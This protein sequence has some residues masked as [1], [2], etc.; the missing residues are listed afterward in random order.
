M[1]TDVLAPS[2]FVLYGAHPLDACGVPTAIL[3]YT[4]GVGGLP[5][6]VTL[7]CSL[8]TLVQRT[9]VV[10]CPRFPPSSSPTF[11]PR[12]HLFFCITFH[13]SDPTPP[14]PSALSA[15]RPRRV[16]GR[17]QAGGVV[18]MAPFYLLVRGKATQPVD[19]GA[20]FFRALPAGA[21][22]PG[23]LETA[24]RALDAQRTATASLAA[25]L[26]GAP[27]ATLADGGT[28]VLSDYVSSLN[29]FLPHAATVEARLPWT[30][31]F[32][33]TRSVALPLLSF[34]RAA[35]LADL[36]VATAAAG[37]AEARA[38][39]AEGHKAALK[40]FKV[41][42]GLLGHLAAAPPPIAAADVTVDLSSD[43]LA[44]LRSAMLANAQM[45]YYRVAVRAK[46]SEGL[47]SKLAAGVVKLLD[48]TAAHCGAGGL[49]ADLGAREVLATPVAAAARLFSAEAHAHAAAVASAGHD[50][51][52][53]LGHL[54]E[55]T[56]ALADARHIVRNKMPPGAAI[57][58]SILQRVGALEGALSVRQERADRENRSIYL[59]TAST[60]LPNIEARIAV[61]PADV[62][63][64]ATG[65]AGADPAS[66][67]LFSSTRPGA[68]TAARAAM[69][70]TAYARQPDGT[71]AA[72]AADAA[73][74]REAAVAEVTAVAEAMV[75]TDTRTL[76]ESYTA[77]QESLLAADTAVA[78]VSSSPVMRKKDGS[79][80]GGVGGSS[81]AGPPLS[82]EVLNN[83]RWAVGMGGLRGLEDLS[84]EVAAM[85]Q[86]VQYQVS[87][88]ER[89]LAAEA[90]ADERL[91]ADAHGN[92][93]R[94]PSA[95]LTR[96]YVATLDRVKG[97]LAT[98]AR[99]D[100]FVV[101]R[102]AS[103]RADLGRLD[104][105]G[106][107]SGVTVGSGTSGGGGVHQHHHRGG[108]LGLGGLGGGGRSDD[109]EDPTAAVTRCLDPLH[110]QMTQAR[111]SL[112]A[113][114]DAVAA[115]ELRGALGGISPDVSDVP[116]EPTSRHEWAQ[117]RAAAALVRPHAHA[118]R[119]AAEAR[120]AAGELDK[121][122]TAL[123]RA[124]DAASAAGNDGDGSSSGGGGGDSPDLRARVA[125]AAD[126]AGAARE[127]HGFLS[128]GVTFYT[129][130]GEVLGKLLSDVDGWVAARGWTR[131]RRWRHGWVSWALGAG[132]GGLGSPGTC[133]R[134]TLGGGR[135]RD[136]GRGGLTRGP[137]VARGGWG[138][139]RTPAR[140]GQGQAASSGRSG[141]T[142]A[143]TG[144]TSR[145]VVC[146]WVGGWV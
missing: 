47:A 57:G 110:P 119:L 98:A 75:D 32:A 9:D 21:F 28:K 23:P 92:L 46:V 17:A 123:R 126:A 84:R 130:E 133:R 107:L 65:T 85:S 90:A 63:A 138:E 33:P 56:A 109:K 101:E 80:S 27:G 71:A 64:L 2:L 94:P 24:C 69:A 81:N 95:E 60:S 121:G 31:A 66:V 117:S 105:L 129:K 6:G 103:R 15:T 53:Q 145:S 131:T 10:P 116:T 88:V 13:H 49:E 68:A 118:V 127:L 100:A 58:D 139:A 144:V 16:A 72:A 112:S 3:F 87:T 73:R 29:L 76:R 37:A 67:A 39:A 52:S 141:A 20:A 74:E 18:A 96:E 83:V 40:A 38:S 12:P 43:G 26:A 114:E 59:Q 4:A 89:A 22:H 122:V 70:A 44:A 125:A 115:A 146:G 124:A 36:A 86:K 25:V 120:R 45:A 50:M 41:A 132:V 78:E 134:P 113:G 14:F 51:A 61:E 128:Q 136:A 102:L 7:V 77:L 99:S 140:R 104:G 34:E 19:I 108:F 79:S 62:D 135:G 82:A 93:Q 111:A 137:R 1:S 54:R 42:A 35:V 8:A 55:A 48:A 142:T 5:G 91:R 143:P 11:P 30:D 97:E 106:D